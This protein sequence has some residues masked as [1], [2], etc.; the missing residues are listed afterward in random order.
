MNKEHL[1]LLYQKIFNRKEWKSYQKEFIKFNENSLKNGCQTAT[2]DCIFPC[3]ND[4][5][6]SLLFSTHYLYHPAWAARVLAKIKPAEHIDISST[7]T[8]STIMSAFIPI[9]YYEY[10]PVDFNLSNLESHKVDLKK[11]PFANNSVSSLSCMHVVEHIGLGRYGDEI[12]SL[13]DEKAIE[14]LKRVVKKGGNLL[15]VVPVGKEK[16]VFNAHRIYSYEKVLKYFSN[17]NLK[18]FSLVLDDKSIANIRCAFG[19]KAVVSKSLNNFSFIEN[20]FIENASK[21][22]A[23]QQNYGCGCFWFVKSL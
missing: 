17:W 4:K 8:F 16:I 19:L 20:C 18:E 2:K 7:I 5:T 6:S 22:I 12:D 3:F 23:D 1:K 11:L 9:K 15:F 21:E 13:G 14:E 10:R